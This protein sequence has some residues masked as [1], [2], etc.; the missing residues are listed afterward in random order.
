VLCIVMSVALRSF[1]IGVCFTRAFLN[2]IRTVAAPIPRCDYCRLLMMLPAICN[3][4]LWNLRPGAAPVML[5]PR[6]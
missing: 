4:L 2:W 6:N 5:C 1:H 3:P